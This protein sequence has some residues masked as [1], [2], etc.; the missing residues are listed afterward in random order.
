MKLSELREKDVINICNGKKIGCVVDLEFNQK[1]C[2]TTALIV[3]QG[4]NFFQLFSNNEICIPWCNIKQIGSDVIL[5][6]LTV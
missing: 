4:M 5:V 3:S 1:T 6:E 2:Q